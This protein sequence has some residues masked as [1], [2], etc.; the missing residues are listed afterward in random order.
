MSI[1]I[2]NPEE[3]D[4]RSAYTNSAKLSPLPVTM[5]TYGFKTVKSA[6]EDKDIKD[7]YLRHWKDMVEVLE[8]GTYVG[9]QEAGGDV[10]SAIME[11]PKIILEHRDFIGVKINPY[12]KEGQKIKLP[13]PKITILTADAVN[14]KFVQKQFKLENGKTFDPGEGDLN[15]F[16]SFYAS[17]H[18]DSVLIT[19]PLLDKESKLHLLEIMTT[20]GETPTGEVRILSTSAPRQVTWVSADVL[21]DY[22]RRVM[23]VIYMMTLNP[24]ATQAYV[25]IPTEEDVAVNKKRLRKGKRP[26]IEFKLITIDGK[27]KD[28]I[29]VMPTGTH[30]SPRQHWR[31]GHWRQY[32][33]GKTVFINPMLVGDEKNGKII[34]DYAVGTYEDRG[35]ERRGADNHRAH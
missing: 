18:G 29:P 34:K 5:S 15:A 8:A 1:M 27:K 28:P 12:M 35:H 26:L 7:I 33:S 6:I 25:S 4:N 22:V 2:F 10:V 31:R 9:T 14:P 24:A 17:Q 23:E 19:V 3:H 11:H 30:A 16:W 32:S 20:Y 13:F 21:N